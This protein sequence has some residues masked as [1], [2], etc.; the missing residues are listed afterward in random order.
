M[1]ALCRRR[2]V[3]ISAGATPEPDTDEDDAKGAAFPSNSGNTGSSEDPPMVPTPLPPPPEPWGVEGHEESDC[4]SVDS[5]EEMLS[6]PDISAREKELRLQAHS[7]QHLM[8]HLP[9]NRFCVY[10]MR[11]K[12]N[13]QGARRKHRPDAE[14]PTRFGQC[15]TCDHMI[16]K[17]VLSQGID[18][19][20]YCLTFYDDAT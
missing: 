18:A 6:N 10:C 5:F 15:V 14:R 17:D 13:K 8:T 1:V 20:R 12:L 7:L 2:L 16:T 9:K 3:P 11:A 19:E 4:D